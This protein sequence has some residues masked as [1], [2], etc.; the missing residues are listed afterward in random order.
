M[1]LRGV[2]MMV[3]HIRPVAAPVSHPRRALVPDSAMLR[4]L[5]SLGNTPSCHV[6]HGAHETPHRARKPCSVVLTA[7]AR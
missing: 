1:Q 6:G 7:L 5:S 3:G 2:A 4:Q